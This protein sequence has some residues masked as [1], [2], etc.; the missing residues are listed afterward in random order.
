MMALLRKSDMENAGPNAMAVANRLFFSVPVE[1]SVEDLVL[2]IR[3]G[4][5]P[6]ILPEV[7]YKE[8]KGHFGFRLA[9]RMQDVLAPYT[10]HANLLKA[11]HLQYVDTLLGAVSGLPRGVV[12]V[13][14]PMGF[15]KTQHV[16]AHLVREAKA[17]GVSV[18]AMC[19]R[20]SLT[21]ELS[22]RLELAN[23]AKMQGEDVEEVGGLAVCLPST[24][25]ADIVEMMPKPDVVFIDEVRQVLAFLASPE[26]CRTAD[27]T[28][29]GVYQR[30]RQLIAGARTVIVADAHVD[31]RTLKF[32][33]ECRPGEC[34]QIIIAE[35]QTVNRTVDWRYGSSRSV[36]ESIIAGI[37]VEL[38]AG[39]KVWLACESKKFA[40]AME[41]YFTDQCYRAIAITAETK[42]REAQA[43]F[44]EDADKTSL[45]YDIVIASPVISSG[46]SIEHRGSPHF[47]LVAFLGSGNAITPGD[48]VQQ[49]ARVR[50]V[51]RF[52][53][54]IMRNNLP[55]RVLKEQLIAGR[56]EGLAVQGDQI[57]PTPY[58]NL[59]AGLQADQAN[60]RANFAAGLYWLLEREGWSV[61]R[62]S[63]ND[64]NSD[65]KS[66]IDAERQARVDSLLAAPSH[67]VTST[68]ERLR[69]L[70]KT[71]S[72]MTR[73]R[74]AKIADLEIQLEA[75][76]IRETLG[77]RTLLP[78]DVELWDEGRLLGKLERFI[79]FFSLEVLQPSFGSEQFSEQ[80]LRSA[81]RKQYRELFAGYDISEEN[82]LTPQTASH[83]LDCLMINPALYAACKIVGSKYATG[84]LHKS[85][86][87]VPLK[88]PTHPVKEVKAILERAGLGAIGKQSRVS[89][90][91]PFLVNNK[92]ANCDKSRVWRYTT[93]G[94]AL[95]RDL[96]RVWRETQAVRSGST[97]EMPISCR[98][99]KRS[100]V[101]V[102]LWLRSAVERM[103]IENDCQFKTNK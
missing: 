58:D 93:R 62:G 2:W 12:V 36:R 16:G 31:D 50:Y 52:L 13:Q 24:T 90:K 4:L 70:R 9:K 92:G 64:Q 102:S 63:L 42:T 60:G 97:R 86:R 41:R 81:R 22:K 54:G 17:Q 49:L 88:R 47:T 66:A 5:P 45:D 74:Q 23:Y 53:V 84:Y 83:I 51:D 68:V 59:V 25:R 101:A 11:H 38:A 28:A 82:W 30:L 98:Q 95:M 44:L 37:M 69:A 103:E 87:I 67:S 73:E 89:Q 14:A 46:L 99:L 32:L 91:G 96:A 55:H 8:L 10:L 71:H 43:A 18:M 77:V 72:E 65:I 19:H 75:A 48:A 21:A 6:D 39:G 34:F 15:G 35:A 76:R 20:I 33:E 40:Q 100:L 3:E 56:S 26:F 80:S 79:D 27:A 1:R 29:E 61:R 7:F 85:G 57:G 94:L 78:E